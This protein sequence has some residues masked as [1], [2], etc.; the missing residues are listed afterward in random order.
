MG[1]RNIPEKGRVNVSHKKEWIGKIGAIVL[2]MEKGVLNI[3]IHASI[4]YCYLF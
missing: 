1:F 4:F 3:F 2:K